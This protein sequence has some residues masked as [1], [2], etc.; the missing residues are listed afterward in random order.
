MSDLQEPTLNPLE[1][2]AAISDSGNVAKNSEGVTKREL[3]LFTPEDAEV[4]LVN[5]IEDMILPHLERTDTGKAGILLPP[6]PPKLTL[7]QKKN[8]AI[9][10]AFWTK[11]FHSKG[12]MDFQEAYLLKV[13]RSAEAKAREQQNREINRSK[14]I[15]PFKYKGKVK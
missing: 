10:V 14:L 5:F 7:E 2:N 4:D 8:I 13:K 9:K 15:L 12:A 3:A 6:P 1:C 11:I